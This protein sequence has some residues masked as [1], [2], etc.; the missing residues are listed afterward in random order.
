[1]K[2]FSAPVSIG[3]C[4][5]AICN[6]EHI[7]KWLSVFLSQPENKPG[8]P[9]IS[10]IYFCREVFSTSE[11]SPKTRVWKERKKN[12]LTRKRRRKI[13]SHFNIQVRLDSEI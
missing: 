6:L 9:R 13:P 12:E 11:K 10:I 7:L 1:M 8:I 4:S 2:F 3:M 5:F